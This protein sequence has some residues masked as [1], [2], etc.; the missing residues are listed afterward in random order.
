MKIIEGSVRK[1]SSPNT[2]VV[3]ITKKVPHR[4]YGKLIKKTS[5]YK[6][7]ITGSVVKIGDKVRIV[8]VR[9][10]SKDKTFKLLVSEKK[11]VVA[12]G[13]QTKKQ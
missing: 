3:E 13:R 9:P 12:G 2:G 11:E 6:V 5:T 10:I 1:V 7:D 8:E 4:M